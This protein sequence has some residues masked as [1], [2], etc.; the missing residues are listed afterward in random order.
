LEFAC[1]YWCD[2]QEKLKFGICQ[3]LWTLVFHKFLLLLLIV[4][5]YLD[6][7]ETWFPVVTMED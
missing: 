4:Q 5:E 1:E 7:R 3:L 2:V 6:L